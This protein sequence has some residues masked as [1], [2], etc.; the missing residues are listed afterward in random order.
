[1]DEIL[2]FQELEKGDE[3]TVIGRASPVSERHVALQVVRQV[4]RRGAPW[5]LHR[6]RKRGLRGE[7]C[8]PM[9]FMSFS[10]EPGESF[11]L[12]K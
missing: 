12:S 5:T 3:V 6:G 9:N 4:Q 8:S 1:V 7:G 11:K 10:V 2:F